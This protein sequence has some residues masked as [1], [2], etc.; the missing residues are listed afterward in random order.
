MDWS[1]AIDFLL[2]HGRHGFH[3]RIR[4]PKSRQ[5]RPTI[6]SSRFQPW[7]ADAKTTRTMEGR[8]KAAHL[9]PNQD[10]RGGPPPSACAARGELRKVPG[11]VPRGTGLNARKRRAAFARAATTLN[12]V[13]DEPSPSLLDHFA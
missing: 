11:I 12:N 2:N 4:V 10:Q 1:P 6:A 9:A 3:G 8:K 7:V 13:R 5:G